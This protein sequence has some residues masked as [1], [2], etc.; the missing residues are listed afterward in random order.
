MAGIATRQDSA[1]ALELVHFILRDFHPRN[2][3]IELWDGERLEPERG[4]FHRFTWRIKS[5]HALVSALMSSNRQV[6]LGKGFVRGE[7][8]IDGDMEAVFPL[9]DFLVSRKWSTRERFEVASL[10]ARLAFKSDGRNGDEPRLNGRRHSKGRDQQA[11]HYHYDVSNEFYRLWLDRNMLYSSA[12]F[13]D[14]ADDLEKAQLRKLDMICQKLCLR[15][16]ERLIDI[17]CGWGGLI[18][19]AAREYGVRAVGITPSDA[20][21]ELAR[22]RIQEAGLTRQCEVRRLDYREMSQ[23]GPCD[24]LSSIGM[25]EHVGEANLQEYFRKAFVILRSGGLFLN[26]G[27]GTEANCPPTDQPTFTDIYVFPDGE[28]VPISRMLLF[29]EDAGFEVEEVE[30]LRE[31][32]CRTT[33]EWLY[34]LEAQEARAREI[35]GEER[36][37]IWRLYLAGS[38]YYFQKGWLGLYYT[39]LK[40]HAE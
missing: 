1:R 30:N 3:T 39:T 16:G 13:G 11:I 6:T 20:Q 12:Y 28:L 14:G 32:Y 5:P 40:K 10:L 2:F 38:A 23:L 15:A 25:V 21:L 24:K 27:I 22:E 31:H 35:V 7:F 4:Q 8:D 36:Y 19:H 17:G 29:A 34:R 37:R 26:S 33:R 18:I 9:V